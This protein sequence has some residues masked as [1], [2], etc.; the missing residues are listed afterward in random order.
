MRQPSNAQPDPL[1]RQLTLE[2][3]FLLTSK[4]YCKD[5][6][7][8]HLD[9]AAIYEKAPP[10]HSDAKVPQ[11]QIVEWVGVGPVHV[12]VGLPADHANAAR[13]GLALASHCA[14]PATSVRI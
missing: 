8:T 7:R 11:D 4:I 6:M 1:Q 10:R 2:P 9:H 3:P 5:D 13:I 14:G 12:E